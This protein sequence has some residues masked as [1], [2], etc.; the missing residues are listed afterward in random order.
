MSR[1]R[2]PTAATLR[3]GYGGLLGGISEV[4][5]A[6][7]HASARAVNVLMT[8][9]YWEVGRRIVEFEQGGSKRAEYGEALL[10][11]LEVDL[12][13][14]LG[15]GFSRQNLQNMRQFYSVCSSSWICQRLSGISASAI[16]Q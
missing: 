6:A 1:K 4:L 3:A 5:D 16:C 15:R 14:R 8:A 10:K 2:S 9:T 13:A 7:R 11:R 12:T